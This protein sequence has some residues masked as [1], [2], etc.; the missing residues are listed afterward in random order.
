MVYKL[1]RKQ[2]SFSTNY[3]FREKLCQFGGRG[4]RKLFGF[5]QSTR[6][7]L[8]PTRKVASGQMEKYSNFGSTLEHRHAGTQ[9]KDNLMLV[10]ISYC[11]LSVNEVASVLD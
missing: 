3:V 10:Q 5:L 7:Q 6:D 8:R 1:V 4:G 9:L 11:K 2:S